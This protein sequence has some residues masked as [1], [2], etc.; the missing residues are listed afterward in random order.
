MNVEHQFGPPSWEAWRG[1][2]DAHVNREVGVGA[3]PSGW[4]DPPSRAAMDALLEELGRPQYRYRRVLVAGTNGKTTVTRACS[5]LLRAVGLRVGTYTSPHLD[6]LNER[7]A[8]DGALVSDQV[9]ARAFARIAAIEEKSS[10]VLSWFEI[11][12]AAAMLWFAWEKV[13]LPVIEVGLG[14]ANDATASAM[15][16]LVAFT[17]VDLDHTEIFGV[18][19]PDVAAAEA[20]IVSAG[21]GLVLGETDTSLHG[22]FTAHHPHPLWI[23]GRDFDVLKRVSVPE[24][25][26][27]TLKTPT[28][29]YC[30]VPITLKGLEHTQNVSLALAAAECAV[31]TVPE[32]VVRRALSVLR[33]PG[34][35]EVV[36]S[37]PPV[38]LDGAHNPAGARALAV[39]L[40]ES[41]PPG[42][43]TYVIGLSADKP[44]EEIVTALGI[45][46]D[47]RVVCCSADTPRARA[48][49]DLVEI[50]RA[51][52]PDSAVE[53]MPSVE[54]ALRHAA[55]APSVPDLVVVTG[56]LYVVAEA[57]RMLGCSAEGLYS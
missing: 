53:A 16:A 19:R 38:L 36:N 8:I 3:P 42:R 2:L 32:P 22:C 24:G 12:T 7:I 9:L 35:V 14:G 54:D 29:I 6:R 37:G 13:D 10:L 27:V 31:G 26:L 57:R 56:S 17:N 49:S 21:H 30:D 28:A 52:L 34:R 33:A 44:A 4:R 50:V 18:T 11:V 40:A 45:R 23:R 39:V 5:A 48:A 25:Q 55:A 51:A 47:D 1:W 41:F 43:R 46:P 20:T 15:P